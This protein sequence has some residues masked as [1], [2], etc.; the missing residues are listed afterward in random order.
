MAE[1][2]IDAPSFNLTLGDFSGPLD[3]LCHLVESRAID[4]AEVRLVDVLSQY[5]A[6]LISA[7]RASLMDIAEFFAMASRLV[8]GKVRSL[9]P[10][11]ND[12][13]DAPDDAA[14]D[15]G[16]DEASE[17]DE[18][19]RLREM[20]ERFRPYRAAARLL[21]ERQA[22]RERYITRDAGEGMPW[23]DI[24]DL[25]G[26][27]SRWWTMIDAFTRDMEAH[28]EMGFMDEIPDA[29]PEEVAVESRMNEIRDS[30]AAS[31]GASLRQL[32][33]DFGRDGLIV[34]LLALLEMSRLGQ[35]HLAQGEPWG[36]VEIAAA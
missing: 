34:T 20:L 23:F 10:R 5:A 4:P 16:G 35:V 15:L 11:V 13:E 30:L 22:D 19:E 9:M 25:Y 36:D 14:D 31:G 17:D 27:A 32:V 2:S 6:Y 28:T 12:E 26:L 21:A 8:L 33:A 1:Q 7:N 18:E 3:M 24:G 29:V